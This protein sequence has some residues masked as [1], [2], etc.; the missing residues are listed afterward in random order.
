MKNIIS[1]FLSMAFIIISVTVN[2]QQ[3]T[4]EQQ[5]NFETG[6]VEQFK[7][8]FPADSYN[9]CINLKDESFSPLAFSTRH[10]KTEIFNFLI[11]NGADVNLVCRGN[12][13]LMEAAKFNTPVLAKQLLKKGADQNTKDAN[14]LT[15][16]DYAVKYQRTEILKLLN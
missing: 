11:K 15:A 10:N 9:K 16:K 8:A 3:M 6:N 12:T 14:G 4:K 2:A 13:A 5:K 7:N 1:T